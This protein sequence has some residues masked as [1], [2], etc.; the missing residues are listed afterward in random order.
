MRA[1]L[2]LVGEGQCGTGEYSSKRNKRKSGE[3]GGGSE[4]KGQKSPKR[5]KFVAETQSRRRV[6]K[7]K[8]QGKLQTNFA[9]V[10]RI[11]IED[12]DQQKSDQ[13]QKKSVKKEA[14]DEERRSALLQLQWKRKRE[15]ESGQR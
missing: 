6:A 13:D 7:E 3:P 14:Q 2:S 8:I 9:A 1:T 5:M 12:Q 11:L 15:R 4:N 10:R